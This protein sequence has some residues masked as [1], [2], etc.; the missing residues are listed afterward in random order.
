MTL[1][2]NIPLTKDAV[3]ALDIDIVPG[4]RQRLIDEL[5]RREVLSNQRE[6]FLSDITGRALQT[7]ARWIDEEKPGLPDLKSLAIVCL[8]FDMDANWILGLTS[9][10]LP[11]PKQQLSAHVQE[12]L[13]GR[14]MPAFDWIGHLLAQTAPFSGTNQV[15]VMKG[16]DMV[17][18]IHDGAPFFFDGTVNEVE[19]NGIYV[20][21]YQGK[22]LVRHIEIIVGEGL[23]L[24]CENQRYN[25]TL[26]KI[27]KAM[28]TLKILGR[29]KAAINVNRF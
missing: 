20:L 29:I 24:R 6:H 21:E 11:F 13:Y 2:N 7:V 23:L 12:Q 25:P 8:Q 19:V 14:E 28:L 3:R 10:R 9:N 26:V 1:S 22:R 5:D 4:V 17:P 18:L 27:S 16:D 15:G